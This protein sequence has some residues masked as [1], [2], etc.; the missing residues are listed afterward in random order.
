MRSRGQPKTAYRGGEKKRKGAQ[1]LDVGREWKINRSI[2][3]KKFFGGASQIQRESS[4]GVLVR[5][6]EI[7]RQARQERKKEHTTILY[8]KREQGW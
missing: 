5:K 2:R 4:A 1:H 3:S 7:Y 8:V 6:E